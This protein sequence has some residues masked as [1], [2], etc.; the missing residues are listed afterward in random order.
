MSKVIV[1][2]DNLEAARAIQANGVCIL[3]LDLQRD[4]PDALAL[5][6]ANDLL[7]HLASIA[8]PAI[9]S[10]HDKAVDAGLAVVVVQ[11]Q[12]A[13]RF[14]RQRREILWLIAQRENFLN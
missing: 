5:K 9:L 6:L 10:A 7:Q 11:A 1:G 14:P 4:R 2:R 12:G 13:Q 3:H 8:A